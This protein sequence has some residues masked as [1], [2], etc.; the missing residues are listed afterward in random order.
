M[1]RKKTEKTAKKKKKFV[2]I[3]SHAGSGYLLFVLKIILRQKRNTKQQTLNRAHRFEGNEA[4]KESCKCAQ[5]TNRP[6]SCTS[7]VVSCIFKSERNQTDAQTQ[8]LWHSI[9]WIHFAVQ[10]FRGKRGVFFFTVVQRWQIE[11]EKVTSLTMG[12]NGNE[13][14]R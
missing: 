10:T 9:W 13:R 5:I 6:G 4:T 2:E 1:K 7:F 11:V 8:S 14:R 3:V 12:F